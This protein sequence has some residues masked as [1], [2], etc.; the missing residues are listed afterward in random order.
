MVRFT[1]SIKQF[2]QQ[3]EKTGWTYIEIPAD[4]A[5]EINPGCKKSFRVKGKLD[6]H[7]IEKAALLP[8]GGGSFILPLNASIRKNIH[9]GKGAM[10]NVQMTIDRQPLEVDKDFM[11]CLGDEP[12]A[13]SFFGSLPRSHQLYFSKWITSAK[14][15][16]TRARR[17]AQAVTA[18]SKKLGYGEMIRMN[19]DLK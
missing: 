17:I 10:L 5:E 12:A 6:D 14:T 9:K 3:G 11:D 15:E 18:L 13:L 1:T 7:R 2:N 16:Q 19:R 4:I 8:M